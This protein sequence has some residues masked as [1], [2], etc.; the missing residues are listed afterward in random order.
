[1]KKTQDKPPPLDFNPEVEVS[2]IQPE[3]YE[4]PQTVAGITEAFDDLI[5]GYSPNPDV[6]VAYPS[7]A[8]IQRLLNKGA[9][10]TTRTDL[11]GYFNGRSSLFRA[12]QDPKK[13]ESLAHT[14]GYPT[15]SW[16]TFE[17]AY[18]DHLIWQRQKI[19][20]T[21]EDPA[22]DGG[23]IIGYNFYPTY[24]NKKTLYVERR[25][26]GATTFGDEI[27]NKQLFNLIFRGIDPEGFEVI[28]LD[29]E[30]GLLPDKPPPITR[31]E[32]INASFD[33][34]LTSTEDKDSAWVPPMLE[35]PD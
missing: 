26:T 27:S 16:E 2:I 20:E 30:W 10:I 17:D 11:T 25:M 9:S 34:W 14:H 8:W 3:K 15:D 13:M 4:G 12:S 32:F 33:Q 7:E 29:S 22:I 24:S 21:D 6:E 19:A 5:Y 23:M 35:L 31:E 1:M 18:I 28:Y